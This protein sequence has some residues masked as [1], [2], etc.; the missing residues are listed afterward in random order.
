[1]ARYRTVKPDFWDDEKIA[2]LSYP[3][4][5]LFIGTWNFSDD[6]GV[7]KANPIWL[8]SKIFPYDETL[9]VS[10][11]KGMLLSLVNARMLIPFSFLGESYYK[12]RTFDEHQK[13][14]KKG[15]RTIPDEI[16]K[17]VD[18]QTIP[19][20][21]FPDY[22]SLIPRRLPDDSG[23]RE[24]RSGVECKGEERSVKD[25]PPPQNFQPFLNSLNRETDFFGIHE[26]EVLKTLIDE[27]CTCEDFK[28]AFQKTV[29]RGAPKNTLKY[30]RNM[31]REAKD[32]RLKDSEEEEKRRA[33]LADEAEE[34]V[35]TIEKS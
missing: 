20:E 14:E 19:S 4:R 28:T 23:T 29:E 9:R 35:I 3:A 8:R 34:E 27:G 1:V 16:A 33:W 2:R 26:Q 18:K 17:F 15:E 31:I 10:E 30:L 24:E 11:V 5:L 12:I 13:V 7:V 21:N 25:E 6:Y 32:A 22:S